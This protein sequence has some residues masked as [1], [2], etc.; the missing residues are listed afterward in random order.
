MKKILIAEDDE[1]I[2]EIERD[3]ILNQGIDVEIANDGKTAL[4][5]ALNGSFNLVILDI[6]IPEIDGFSLCRT[7]R[8]KLDIP[9]IMVTA[10]KD[11]IDKI[12]ALGLGADDFIV[13]P[14]SPGELVARVR[15]HIA[16]YERISNKT[17]QKKNSADESEYKE[18]IFGNLKLVQKSRRVFVAEKEITLAKKEFDLLCLFMQNPDRVFSKEELY[19]RLWSD[20]SSGDIATVAVHI[21]RL[22]EKLSDSTGKIQTVWGAGYRFTA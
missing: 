15:S 1:A 6:M 17:V 8:E 18:L 10:K 12:R 11:D 5:L 7:L 14:F 4:E 3:Y 16:F 9:I 13:K 2:A 22:R 19:E 20:D 21:N